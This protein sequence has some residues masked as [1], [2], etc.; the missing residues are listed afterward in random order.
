MLIPAA[1]AT[2]ATGATGGGGGVVCRRSGRSRTGTSRRTTTTTRSTWTT[3]MPA[4]T[5]TRTR[6]VEDIMRMVVNQ[7]QRL[8]QPGMM[9][10]TSK[11]TRS[12]RTQKHQ[13]SILGQALV[14]PGIDPCVAKTAL[15]AMS[16]LFAQILVGFICFRSGLLS[17]SHVKVLSRVV[18]NLLLPALLFTSVAK[19]VACTPLSDLLPIPTFA[20]L[21]IGVGLILSQVVLRILRLDT[22]SHNARATQVLSAFG[23]SGVLPLAFVSALFRS[24]PLIQAKAEAFVALY[25]LGWSPVFWGLGKAIMVKEDEHQPQP[26]QQQQ[27]QDESH[28]THPVVQQQQQQEKK[29]KENAKDGSSVLAAADATA[30]ITAAVPGVET[31]KTALV[32]AAGAAGGAAAAAGGGGASHVTASASTTASL[33]SSSSSQLALESP[34]P[35][36]RDSDSLRINDLPSAAT[37]ATAGR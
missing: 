31:Q 13:K 18:F 25:L 34:A 19:T 10:T 27:S 1:T 26:Q 7:R 30:S 3:T 37:A 11:T 9:I 14:V 29:E 12:S 20:I 17:T 36:D 35:I 15:S 24:Q 23:N 21:Q 6:R 5:T 28:Q 16:E 8:L 2:A 4:A 22:T 33:A 32:A